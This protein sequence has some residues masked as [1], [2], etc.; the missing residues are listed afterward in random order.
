[1]N[2]TRAPIKVLSVVGPGRSGTTVLGSILGEIDGISCTG[3]L[4]WLW[5]RGVQEQRPCGCGKPPTD[6]VVWSSVVARTASSSEPGKPQWTLESL[7]AAQHEIAKLGNRR[8]VLRSVRDS[9]QGWEPLDRVRTAIGSACHAFADVTG[10]RVVVD[11]SKR[12]H[13]AAVFATVEGVDHY[14]IH[15]VR[16][17][18]AVVHSWRRAKT[19]TVAGQTRT[20]KARRLPSSVRRWIANCLGSEM[21][22]RRIPASRWLEMRYEDFALDPRGAIEAILGLLHEDGKPP[23]ESDDTVLLRPNHMV[24]GNPSRFTIGS[25]E[26]RSDEAWRTQMRRRDQN[27][28]ALATRPLMRRYGYAGHGYARRHAAETVTARST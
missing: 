28:V 1:V 17:P 22:R 3:E 6:C 21:L 10:A 25:V 20:M 19:F 7:I 24:A 16:D 4:R 5:E 27:L 15:V 9:Q 23:F 8:R 13:D 14:V 18:R 12:P 26:I 11:T 2:G